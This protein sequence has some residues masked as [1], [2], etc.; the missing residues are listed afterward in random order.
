MYMENREKVICGFPIVAFHGRDA[1]LIFFFVA[2]VRSFDF[3]MRRS[4]EHQFRIVRMLRIFAPVYIYILMGGNIISDAKS[5]RDLRSDSNGDGG[6]KRSSR[7][8]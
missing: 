4:R 3:H 6:F 1:S 2:F 7:N 8:T 5:A